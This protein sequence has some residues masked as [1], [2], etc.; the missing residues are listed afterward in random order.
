MLVDIS[1]VE[2]AYH[3]LSHPNWIDFK[4]ASRD[5]EPKWSFISA[6]LA[7]AAEISTPLRSWCV[8]TKGHYH[9]NLEGGSSASRSAVRIA[10]Q[11]RP[12]RVRHRADAAHCRKAWSQLATGPLWPLR[13]QW[14]LCRPR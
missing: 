11:A 5:T 14:H 9:A 7:K 10:D 1:A 6:V 2:P 4:E 13:F 12:G 3:W 8:R